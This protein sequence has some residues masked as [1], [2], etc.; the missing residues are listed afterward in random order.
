MVEYSAR[1]FP[2]NHTFLSQFATILA[3]NSLDPQGELLVRLNVGAWQF[4]TAVV[5]LFR[6]ARYIFQCSGEPDNCAR[7]NSRFLARTRRRV[8]LLN[9]GGEI[10]L[11]G[12]LENCGSTQGMNFFT[13]EKKRLF[14]WVH[15]SSISVCKKNI[16]P[17]IEEECIVHLILIFLMVNP[18]GIGLCFL[19]IEIFGWF[20]L[21][22][23]RKVIRGTN[24]WQNSGWMAKEFRDIRED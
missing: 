8:S 19:W 14:H 13:S 21:D 7:L 11:C 12:R 17:I 20:I 10:R 3:R 5:A 4:F 9:Q 1:N 24:W 2:S 22:Y 16:R 6:A 15:I 18:F 23:N